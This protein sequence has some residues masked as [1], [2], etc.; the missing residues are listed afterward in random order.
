MSLSQ[1][2]QQHNSAQCGLCT[3]VVSDYAHRRGSCCLS[4]KTIHSFRSN[5]TRLIGLICQRN[6]CLTAW[7]NLRRLGTWFFGIH[8]T[9]RTCSSLILPS[10]YLIESQ[11]KQCIVCDRLIFRRHT[12]CAVGSYSKQNISCCNLVSHVEQRHHTNYSSLP[13]A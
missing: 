8:K 7:K 6:A 11:S 3:G 10:G 13:A 2:W 12:N 5:H 1:Q 4:G 9:I